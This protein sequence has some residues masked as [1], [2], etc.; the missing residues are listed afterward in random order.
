LSPEDGK[1]VQQAMRLSNNESLSDSQKNVRLKERIQE[2]NK[3]KE[4]THV[5]KGQMVWV[6]KRNFTDKN[7]IFKLLY[8]SLNPFL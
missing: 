2:E 7:T 6:T 4:N 5:L 8:T 1:C 3:R